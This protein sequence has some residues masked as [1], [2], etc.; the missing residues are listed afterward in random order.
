MIRNYIVLALRSLFKHKLTTLINIIGVS[1]ALAFGILGLL[2]V[3]NEWTY[4]RFHENVDHI[5]RICLKSRNRINAITPGPLG[6]AF[7]NEFAGLKIA[8][9]YRSRG[10]AVKGENSFSLELRYVD[11]EF[12]DIFS[13]SLVSGTAALHDVQSILITQETAQKL[14]PNTNPIGQM[15]TLRPTQWMSIGGSP[16]PKGKDH[17]V[18]RYSKRYSQK[19]QSAIRWPSSLLK[20]PRKHIPTHG[21][22]QAAS[23]LLSCSPKQWCFS[24]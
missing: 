8:R 4:D 6:P 9:A 2:F 16:A 18:F 17:I 19:F 20:L 21:I 5:Y 3:H 11:P 15:I 24:K 1:I 12:L 10:N 7:A 13:F 23:A 22:L 14:F